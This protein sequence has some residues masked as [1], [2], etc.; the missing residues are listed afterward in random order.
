[1]SQNISTSGLDLPGSSDRRRRTN[2]SLVGI[3]WV[4]L[5]AAGCQAAPPELLESSSSLAAWSGGGAGPGFVFGGAAGTVAGQR[6]DLTAA[7]VPAALANR[8]TFDGT[9]GNVDNAGGIH[10]IADRVAC[11]AQ[12]GITA[13]IALHAPGEGAARSFSEWGSDQPWLAGLAGLAD[14]LKDITQADGVTPQPIYIRY[15]KEFNQG[16]PGSCVA[17][18]Q[19]AASFHHR[20]CADELFWQWNAVRRAFAVAPNVKLV[21]CPT[22]QMVPTRATQNPAVRVPEELWPGAAAV[23]IIGPDAYNG[24]RRDN[25][26]PGSAFGDFVALARAAKKPFL[27]SETGIVKGFGD[28]SLVDASWYADLFQYLTDLDTDRRV[29]VRVDVLG[30]A[31]FWR[32]TSFGDTT[33]T[34]GEGRQLAASPGLLRAQPQRPQPCVAN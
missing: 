20:S 2:T 25:V 12:S 29:D 15:A 33:L 31:G 32:A 6:Q 34:P 11:D 7:N 10:S 21:W 28:G 4:A 26:D 17:W 8:T 24:K 3:G 16:W 1:M 23:D 13:N 9:S 19:D 5:V 27:I 14:A 30:V 22:G 18:L